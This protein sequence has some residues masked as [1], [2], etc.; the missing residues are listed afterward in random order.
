MTEQ[1]TQ[2]APRRLRLPDGW[3]LGAVLIAAI[4]LAPILSVIWIAFHP[5]ENIWPHLLATVMPRYMG[6]TLLLMAGVGVITAAVGTGA[7]WLVTLYRFPGSGWLSYALLFPLAVPAYVGAYALVDFF[8]Y[9]GALQ[10]TL[11][12]LTGWKTAA[13]Y[14]FP[15]IRSPWAAIVVL[16][17]ALYPYIYLLARQAFREQSG[18]SYEVAR[19]LG[20]GPWAVF[21]RVG[22]P[23]AR[24]SIAAGV[25]LA[26][27]ETVADYGTVT[28]FS[29]Q[30]LTTGIFTTWLTAGN[31]GGAAQIAGVAMGVIVLLLAVERIGRRRARFHGSARQIRPVA[32]QPLRG[33]RG[34]L[35]SLLCF[36]PF[37]MGFVLPVAVMA[38][39]GMRNPQAWIEPGLLRALVN[40]LVAGGAAAA[41]TVAAAV[42]FIYGLRMAGRGLPRWILPVTALGY[43]APGAV[44]ALGLLIPL[45]ALDHRLADGI[46]ALTGHDPG[47]LLTG[48]AAAIVLAYVVRFFGIAQGA[49]DAAFGRI[50]PNLP[51]AA[52]ALGR[53]AGAVLREVYLPMMR[54]S[55]GMALLIVFV[56]CVK[57]LPATLLLRPFNY[58]TL[59]TRTQ[60]LASLE[61]LGQAAP[62][63]LLVM[64]V[65]LVAVA[66]MAR[67]EGRR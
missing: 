12:A 49:V 53:P 23:L 42:L 46:L 44:L 35:A 21:W 17:A 58:N 55:V 26:L 20:S 61:K 3:T 36:L 40:T 34:W 48:S 10:V 5:T 50:S 45:A 24:P 41:I 28:H 13:D 7:A 16:S 65:G 57:E 6:M 38:A 63:A 15:E 62:A 64:G 2:V 39:H 60:E 31:A 59:A 47:L 11:R 8:D 51:L 66:L 22:L 1:N 27:M 54:G 67:M 37:G 30:T 32:A 43:A 25:A 9:S 29:V 18:G 19:A 52:R 14:W 33:W 4:V 56:D